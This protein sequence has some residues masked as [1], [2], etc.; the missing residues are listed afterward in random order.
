LDAAAAGGSRLRLP[1]HHQQKKKKW[2]PALETTV[3][4]RLLSALPS[5][6]ILS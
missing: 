4:R 1:S 2:I 5:V 6:V 3:S